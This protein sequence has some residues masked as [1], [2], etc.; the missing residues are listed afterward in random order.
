MNNPKTDITARAQII[1]EIHRRHSFVLAS[2]ERPDGDAIGSQMAM[3]LALRKLGKE[4][5]VVNK[6]L[7]PPPI[8]T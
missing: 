3:A 7:A 2:H 8:L 1:E 6:D 5:R 4:V